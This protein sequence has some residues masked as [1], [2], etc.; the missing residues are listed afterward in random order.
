MLKALPPADQA[1]ASS[2]EGKK[3]PLVERI[4][5][6]IVEEYQ[7]RM[8]GFLKGE[9]DYLEQVPESLTD[10]VLANGGLK[11]ELAAK[12]ITLERFPVL[13]TYYM[14]MNMDDPVLG[15]YS[16]A[17]LALRR[18]IALSYN[19]REDIA[20]LKKGLALPAQSPLPP[21]VLGY[22]KG[23]RSPV[24]YDPALA[25]A[26]LD[27]FGYKM[28]ADGFRRQPDGTPLILTMYTRTEHGGA[29]AR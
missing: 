26:L 27:R 6:R 23:Y 3:L 12:G 28:G 17:R 13:Q 5:V 29:A 20:L 10:M 2:L 18:A 24:S 21:N 7:S 16:K 1:I 11:P 9:F 19:S 8:L 22:D 25:R 15:G 14:W 4:E